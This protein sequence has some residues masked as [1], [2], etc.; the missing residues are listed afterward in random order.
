MPPE[1]RYARSGDVSIAYQ[2]VGDGPFDLVLAP[3]FVSNVEYAWEEPSLVS[4][5]EQLASFCRLIVFDKRGTGLSDRVAQIATLETRM[6][7]VRAVMDAAGSERAALI[8]YSEGSSMSLLFATTYP[9]RSAALILYGG[10]MTWAW[11]A[12]GSFPSRHESSEAAVRE[13]E[14]RWGEPRYCDEL[15]ANDAPSK[16]H[17]DAFRRWYAT[18]LRLSASPAAAADLLRMAIDT[19]TRAIASSV[20]VPTLVLHRIGDRNVKVD[21][22]R[23]AARQIPRGAIRRASG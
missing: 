6:D 5:Y 15:L 13:I 3:G 1:T 23:F 7:D 2:T 11:M 18:R 8:G 12:D 10:F 21:N 4:F 22:A 9:E 16:L 20:R 19:D 17:D 14:R